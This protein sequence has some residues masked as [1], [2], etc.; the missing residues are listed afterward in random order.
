MASRTLSN[1]RRVMEVVE[2]SVGR[3]LRM[4]YDGIDTDSDVDGMYSTVSDSG[5]GGGGEKGKSR[6]N[7]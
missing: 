2:R 5:G 7:S 3:T 4:G 1:A 6:K